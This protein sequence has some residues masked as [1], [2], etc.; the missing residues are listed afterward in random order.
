M[1]IHE[2]TY[3]DLR[4]AYSGI[5]TLCKTVRDG[6]TEPDAEEYECYSCGEMAVEGI[7]NLLVS[8]TLEIIDDNEK[9]TIKW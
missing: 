2:S 3:H 8:A 7:D 6:D 1:K 4:E 5:C 9:E